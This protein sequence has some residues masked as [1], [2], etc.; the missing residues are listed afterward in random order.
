MA[1]F[2][3]RTRSPE[4]DRETDALRFQRL[5]QLMRH[6]RTEMQNERDGLQSRYENVAASA[7][8]SQEALE[9]GRG[10]AD[11]SSRIDELTGSM[12]RYSRRIASLDSQIAFIAGLEE[13]VAA[14]GHGLSTVRPLQLSE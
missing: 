6:L 11:M 10:G 2:S 1:L 13:D 9:N 8:F 14:F 5:G 3:F 12:L 7:A 4:R